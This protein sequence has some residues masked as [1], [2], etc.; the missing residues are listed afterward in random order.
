VGRAPRAAYHS[1][2]M[3]ETAGNPILIEV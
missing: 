3:T 2:G 1:R